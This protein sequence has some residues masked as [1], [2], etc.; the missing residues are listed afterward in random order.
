VILPQRIGY[1]RIIA[2]SLF[3]SSIVFAAPIAAPAQEA[4]PAP[5]PTST[6]LAGPSISGVVSSERGPLAGVTVAI[7]GPV[8]QSFTTQ[9]D[10]AFRFTGIPAGTY[11]ISAIAAGYE[12][13]RNTVVT[14]G[15]DTPQTLAVTLEI[16]TLNSLRVI[17][18][19]ST[20]G[21]G[22]TAINTSGAAQSTLT[23]QDY[24]DRGQF[25]VQDML[26]EEPGVELTRASS[27]GAPGANTDVAVRGA[28]TYE[29]QTLIDGHAIT[30]GSEGTFLIQ[31]LN[32]LVLGTI[33]VD[34]G[35]G[36]FGNTIQNAVGGTVNFRT[37]SI[38]TDLQG[39]LTTG[40]DSYNGSTYSARVSDTIGKV[41]F[42]AAYGFYGTP[43]YFNGD[44]LSV[45]A[46]GNSVPGQP[47][48]TAWV[49]EAVPAGETFQNRSQVFKLAYNFSPVTS[50]TLGSIAEQSY[51]DYTATLDTVEPF[52]IAPDG[53]GNYNNPKFANLVGKTVL[54]SSTYDNLYLGNFEIDNEPIFTADLRTLAGPGSFL[55]RFFTGSIQRNIDDPQES[56]QISSC[57]AGCTM[58][59]LESP[60]YQTE[61][62]RLRG[63][64]FEYSVPL[65]LNQEDLAQVSYDDHTDRSTACSGSSF[66]FN[67]SSDSCDVNGLL[68][69]SR[70]FSIRG[71]ANVLPK[72]RVGFANYFSDTSFVGSRYDPRA[73]LVWT[74]THN[75]ALR[76]A[77]GTAY[78]APPS[79]FVAPVAGETKAVV[80]GTLEVADA[81]KPET[82]AGVNIGA[83]FRV[84]NDSKF[85]IDVYTTAL[86]NRFSTITIKPGYT[87]PTG[88]SFGVYN[89]VPFNE[90]SEV[91]NA[92]D[93]NE[94]GIEFGYLRA[95]R[96]GFGVLANFD[97]LRA[98]NYNTVIPQLQ[99]GVNLNG[100]QTGTIG[101]DGFETPGFQ[102]PGFPYSH[103]RAQ[104]SYA[105]PSTA[106]VAFGASIYGANNSFGEAGFTLFDFNT[107]LPVNYGLR[108]SASVQNIFN[109]DDYRTLGE[110]GYGYL[111]P[112]EST[113][114]SLFFA[115]PRQVTL[116][117]I[118][119]FGGR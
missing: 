52:T 60:F 46:S 116:Q 5:A 118:Y 26:E 76:F 4:S 119:P 73:T 7:H 113:P 1:F 54:A 11:R 65:G 53:G 14:T 38:S 93:A 30:A 57:N 3:V 34:K 99:P 45:T 19:T 91:Y 74:P 83:D 103:G 75:T 66:D 98:Y 117:I 77:V 90:I 24:I 15:P 112:G 97:L 81:L 29:T 92:S 101:G 82:S 44:I 84:H 55:G 59:T 31:F 56:Q 88:S 87:V 85:T 42:L 35:P 23:S 100:S 111:P 102:I 48:P 109:H 61:N 51:V 107:S 17:A 67:S 6:A 8:T 36:V 16:A 62:D 105:F 104:V 40:Y 20:S 37:P 80:Q 63:Y 50:L 43:G 95:P 47:P 86:T 27:G 22:S 96:V 13:L 94:S 32:P 64:D 89:G 12:P 41:G 106:R 78:V 49:N 79:G 18:S 114:Y 71:F 10:G 108:L 115:P 70:T 9:A 28:S 2:T 110:Y 69:H 25:Q 58:P 33:E 68:L 39:R 21:R 72:V